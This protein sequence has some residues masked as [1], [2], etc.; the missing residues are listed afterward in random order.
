M[1]QNP[2]EWSTAGSTGGTGDPNPT[3]NT[4][5]Q[6]GLFADTSIDPD[7]PVGSEIQDL[8]VDLG[9][10]EDKASEMM[11]YLDEYDPTRERFASMKQELDL[12]GA[13][14]AYGTAMDTLDLKGEQ[15]EFG[16]RG[17]MGAA[18]AGARGKLS[19][20]LQAGRKVGGFGGRQRAIESGKQDIF[21]QTDT[22]METANS[23]EIL[24]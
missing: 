4:D 22:A 7:S 1:P 18:Q 24:H 20:V 5:W 13:E 11:T 21:A 6:Q 16:M 3:G 17:Q 12:F 15:A 2:F 9:L 8:L 10:D 14:S 23:K 19:E